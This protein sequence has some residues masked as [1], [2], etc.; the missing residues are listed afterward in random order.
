MDGTEGKK[1]ADKAKKNALSSVEE[2]DVVMVQNKKRKRVVVDNEEEVEKQKDI[3]KAKHEAPTGILRK[4]CAVAPPS[5]NRKVTSFLVE[6]EEDKEEGELSRASSCDLLFRPSDTANLWDDEEDWVQGLA[7]NDQ[8]LSKKCAKVIKPYMPY[9]VPASDEDYIDLYADEE[10]IWND[11][12]HLKPR[13]RAKELQQ[14]PK[15]VIKE[16]GSGVNGMLCSVVAN[17]STKLL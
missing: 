14:K 6:E 2:E 13:S 7:E 8:G 9:P 5:D 10:R 11:I 12:Q 17:V 4:P 3:M 1:K 15:S 16:S